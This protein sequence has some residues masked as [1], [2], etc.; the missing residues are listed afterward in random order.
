MKE[1]QI[2]LIIGGILH[3]AILTAGAL[4][5][6]VLNFRG[7]LAKVNAMLRQL[8]WVYGVFIVFTLISFG[9]I[10]IANSAALVSG[11]PLARW[12]CGFVAA[13]WTIRL[14][15]QLFVYDP[16]PYFTNAF[17]KLGYHGLTA[18]FTYFTVVY[19]LAA[20]LPA[21]VLP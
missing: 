9:V 13:F 21:E 19:G 18:V 17:F 14:V 15:V 16:S 4:V 2:M 20:L 12:F 1:L 8:V 7:E 6:K 10:S 5:P 3:F 11:A